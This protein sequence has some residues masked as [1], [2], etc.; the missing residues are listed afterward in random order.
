MAS[1]DGRSIFRETHIPPLDFCSVQFFWR[2]RPLH[3]LR[4]CAKVCTKERKGG[5]ARK[6]YFAI[7]GRK[8][9][10]ERKGAAY[11]FAK[12]CCTRYHSC[13]HWVR[14]VPVDA[15]QLGVSPAESS[16][17][18]S[19]LGRGGVEGPRSAAHCRGRQ[20]EGDGRHVHRLS[21]APLNR[22]QRSFLPRIQCSQLFPLLHF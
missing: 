17:G 10:I 12:G 22:L 2:T 1:T 20:K 14:S 18:S 16:G 5:G 21:F 11:F 7:S 13:S 3:V 15:G 6:N 19:R 4:V 9:Q 8:W